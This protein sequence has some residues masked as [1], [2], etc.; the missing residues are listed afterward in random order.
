MTT[1]P[2]HRKATNRTL[3]KII[4]T[5]QKTKIKEI[6][7]EHISPHVAEKSEQQMMDECLNLTDRICRDKSPFYFGLCIGLDKPSEFVVV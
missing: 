3:T 5:Y 2:S 1:I 6:K 7:I 4:M